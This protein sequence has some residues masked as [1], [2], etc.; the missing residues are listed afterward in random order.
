MSSIFYTFIK[1]EKCIWNKHTDT[2]FFYQSLKKSSQ[3]FGN[4]SLT[5]ALKGSVCSVQFVGKHPPQKT[6]TLWYKVLQLVLCTKRLSIHMLMEFMT[7]RVWSRYQSTHV[8]LYHSKHLT[9]S[10][11]VFSRMSTIFSNLVF[12]VK[13]KSSS[14]QRTYLVDTWDTARFLPAN[15]P[16]EDKRQTSHMICTDI[17]M[18]TQCFTKTW[19]SLPFQMA[20]CNV[21]CKDLSL[22]VDVHY[23]LLSLWLQWDNTGECCRWDPSVCHSVERSWWRW[24]QEHWCCTL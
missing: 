14:A 5:V 4:T 11:V 18:H 2:I 16:C 3:Y 19:A 15:Q 8:V 17:T 1:T 9:R 23:R 24:W 22:A 12:A 10:R 20:W 21:Q 7:E 13:M 6:N